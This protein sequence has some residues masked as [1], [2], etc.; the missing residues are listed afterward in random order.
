VKSNVMSASIQPVRD[1]AEIN[2]S[3]NSS[4]GNLLRS[5]PAVVL[6]AIVI[7]DAMRSADTDLWGHIFFGN[8]VLRH[9]QLL[10][11]APFSYACPPGP[12]SWIV[13]DWLFKC[14]LAKIYA[15]SGTIGLKLVTFTLAAAVVILLSFGGAETGASLKIQTIVMLLAAMALLPQ[16]Q[17][18]PVLATYVLFAALM[19][20]L[21]IETYTG[22]APLWISVPILFVWVN[23]HGGYFVGL[24]AMGL[25]TVIRGVQDLAQSRGPRGAVRLTAL[26]SAGLLVTLLNPYGLQDWLSIVS[27]LR[28]P[29][30][31]RYISEFRPFLVTLSNLQRA[32]SELFPFICALLLMT[33]TIIVFLLTPRSDDLALFAIAVVMSIS[34]LYAVRNTALAVI[35][36][37]VPL[38]RHADLLLYRRLRS[39]RDAA[40]ALPAPVWR[41]LQ[42]GI[43]AGALLIA[44]RTGLLSKALPAVEAKPVGALAFMQEHQMKGNVLSEFGWADYLL[45]HDSAH[46][47]IFIESIFEAYYPPRLQDDYAAFYY[48]GPGGAAV[49]DEYPNDFV[50]MPTGSPASLMTAKQP[51]WRLIYRDPVASLFARADSA[52]ARLSNVPY[53]AGSAPPSVFP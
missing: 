9:H 16:M 42:I 48:A 23:L 27:Y 21:E 19:V 37:S 40:G 1:F 14:L 36:C 53:L 11:H 7:A 50:L 15:W 43:A 51:G 6:F 45:F 39:A 25:F 52:A 46:F 44:I 24:V 38:C 10:F 29:F 17:I 31:L 22:R 47:R 33:A 2:E 5:A 35:A 41:I 4:R 30:T 49:L 32:H 26:S 8:I 13:H 3:P 18:R 28:N 20:L 34:A 12:S